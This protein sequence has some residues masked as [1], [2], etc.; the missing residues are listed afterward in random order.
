MLNRAAQI[1]YES[2]EKK[3]PQDRASRHAGY[4]LK[5]LRESATNANPGSFVG[6]VTAKPADVSIR[7]SE[8]TQ[9]M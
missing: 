7:E 1:I 3:R 8:G 5:R 4:Y 2:V 9:F 6:Y